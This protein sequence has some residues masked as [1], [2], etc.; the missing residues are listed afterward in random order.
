MEKRILGIILSL[1]GVLG[2]ILAAVQFMNTTGGTRSIKSI[3]IYGILGA[4]FFFS[5]IS[6]IKNTRDN[7]S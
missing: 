2:L 4:I 1:L 6:L 5:G 3:F 7:P